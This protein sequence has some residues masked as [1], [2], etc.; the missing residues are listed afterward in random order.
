[1]FVQGGMTPLQAIRAATLSGAHYIGMDKEI[2]SLEKG[3]LA[4]LLVL[5]ANPLK[6][7]RNSESI[8]YTIANGRIFDAMTMNE[9]GNHP[10]VR[11]PFYFEVPGSEAWGQAT[12]AASDDQ[13]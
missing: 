10:R 3:K 8:R 2:G 11:Q 5:D 6:N 7:I 12:T 4:D 1:M 9:S 13:E